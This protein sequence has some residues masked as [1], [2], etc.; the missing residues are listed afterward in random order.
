M[1]AVELWAQP[2]RGGDLR[3]VREGGSRPSSQG[4]GCIDPDD[5]EDRNRSRLHLRS[6][7]EQRIVAAMTHLCDEGVVIEVLDGLHPGLLRGMDVFRAVVNKEHTFRDDTE[8]LRCMRVDRG[9]GFGDQQTVGERMV[10]EVGEPGTAEEDAGLH[11]IAKVGQDTGTHAGSLEAPCPI[12]HGLVGLG[13][14]RR[15]GVQQ[16]L[17]FRGCKCMTQVAGNLPPVRVP[18]EF[19][20]VV[21]MTVLPVGLA[22]CGVRGTQGRLQRDPGGGI[23]RTGE[24]QPVVEEDGLD[25]GRGSKGGHVLDM[26]ANGTGC[27]KARLRSGY[28]GRMRFSG[29]TAWEPGVNRWATSAQKLRESGQ[30]LVDLTVSNPAAC[31]L[32]PRDAAAVLQ[33]LAAEGAMNYLPDPL[34]MVT[35]RQAVAGYYRDLGVEA[36]LEQICLT[37]STS[38]AYSFLFRLLCDPGDEVLIARPSYPLFDLLARLDDVTLREYPLHYDPSSAAGWEIDFTALEAALSNRTR[39]VIVVH[40]NNPTGHFVRPEEQ[41]RLEGFC[42]EH[43]LALIADEVFL[44]YGLHRPAAD[45]IGPTTFAHGTACLS[46][47]LSGISKVCALPQ[48]KASW[49][50]ATGPAPLVREAMRRLEIIADTFLSLNAPVQFALGAWLAGRAETQDVIRQRLKD[51]LHALDR[52]LAG[53]LGSRLQQEA[54]WTAVL[55][56]PRFVDGEEFAFAAMERGVLVQPGEFYGLPAGRCVLSLLTV[57]AVWEEGLQRLPL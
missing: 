5:T 24:Y 39:A 15:V 31:G 45:A 1:A 17:V 57:P 42:A 53:S 18:V 13:P 43:G 19:S 34:G 3:G 4:Q 25:G 55:R 37:T 7:V 49:I 2:G 22:E 35:A 9:I 12:D 6:R 33:P 48:M 32:G 51:N 52:R 26:G 29:R 50:V 56:V 46:F 30:T 27:V 36:P 16:G 54:G 8:P 28:A 11:G 47:V 14:Q 41:Q 40:P 44:D 38:E 20:A 21:L 10:V 23:R